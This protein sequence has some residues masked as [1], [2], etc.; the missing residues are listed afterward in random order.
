MTQTKWGRKETVIFPPHSPIYT[1]GAIFFS[2]VIM[3]LCAYLHFAYAMTPL[4]RFYLPYYMRTGIAGMMHK[5]DNYQ[6]L[7]VADAEK[8]TRAATE[9]DVQQGTT[10]S[11]DGKPI[12]LELSGQAR[13]SGLLL[14]YR[15]PKTEYLNKAL[16]HYFEHFV[17]DGE[18]LSAIFR[19]PLTFGF[20]ALG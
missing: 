11:P 4:Q 2:L 16:H 8:R 13:Q 3:G 15:Q 20:T 9:N 12:S 10:P 17:Y 5:T 14:L 7:S 6:L 1:Y 19:L 18:S